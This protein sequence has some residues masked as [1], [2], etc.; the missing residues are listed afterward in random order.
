[1]AVFGF[2]PRFALV[3]ET[4]RE[5]ARGGQSDLGIAA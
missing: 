1:M 2:T 3:D 4:D 5:R